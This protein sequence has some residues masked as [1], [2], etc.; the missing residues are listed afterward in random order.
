M[1]VAGNPNEAH[2][3]GQNTQAAAD[4]A[5]AVRGQFTGA[6][7]ACA[8]AA[9]EASLPG[10]YGGYQAHF[11]DRI[12]AVLTL[13]QTSGINIQTGAAALVATDSD[14]STGFGQAQSTLPSI[15]RG[16]VRAI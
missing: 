9:K 6:A 14:N 15:N 7:Q 2:S 10:A 1:D 13:A 12:N 3:A 11:I 5:N 4:A 8:D 16:S